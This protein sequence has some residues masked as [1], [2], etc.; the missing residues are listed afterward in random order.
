MRKPERRV[1]RYVR[2]RESN[3]PWSNFLIK[4]H[5]LFSWLFCA[6]LERKGTH[7]YWHQGK[8]KNE[9]KGTKKEPVVAK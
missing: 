3:S 5:P 8:P 9:V 6:E 4:P 2:T 1:K 7:T